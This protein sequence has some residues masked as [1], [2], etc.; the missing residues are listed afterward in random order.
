MKVLER[1]AL[2]LFSIIMVIL[3]VTSCLVIFNVVE[4]KTIYKFLEELL[5]DDCLS[6]YFEI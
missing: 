6:F 3:A 1:I 5:K 4:L 2:V